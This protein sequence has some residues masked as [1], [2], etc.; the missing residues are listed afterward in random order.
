MGQIDIFVPAILLLDARYIIPVFVDVCCL[1]HSWSCVCKIL[2][3]STT[4]FGFPQ[5]VHSCVD[6]QILCVKSKPWHTTHVCLENPNSSGLLLKQLFNPSFWMNVTVIVPVVIMLISIHTQ[7]L[8]LEEIMA[9]LTGWWYTYPSEKYEFVSWDDDI[10]NMW[11]VIK[12][13][14]RTTNQLR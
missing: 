8:V 12:A 14:F 11:K 5:N 13:M 7:T 10:P 9:N 4:N 3:L 6:L 2:S 1:N